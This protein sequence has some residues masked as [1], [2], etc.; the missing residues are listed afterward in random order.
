MTFAFQ[1]K[2]ENLNWDMMAEADIDRITTRTDV[3]YLEQLLQNIS[4]A[5]LEKADLHRIGDRNYIKLFKVGQLSL[6]YL[7]FL[8]SSSEFQLSAA[9]RR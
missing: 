4:N 7:L 9:V 5:R 1:P 8:Q 3:A 6:E 2:T